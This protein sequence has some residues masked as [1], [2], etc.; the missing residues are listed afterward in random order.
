[1]T[2][3]KRLQKR[4]RGGRSGTKY[5]AQLLK[6]VPTASPAEL[7]DYKREADK[8]GKFLHRFELAMAE[9][10]GGN[11]LTRPGGADFFAPDRNWKR[12]AVFAGAGYH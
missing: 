6:E 4:P 3:L 9:R 12:S 7:Q 2:L 5:W 10:L 8:L 11:P 1:M